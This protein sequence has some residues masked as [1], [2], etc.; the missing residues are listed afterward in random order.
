MS[1]VR[2]LH[3]KAVGGRERF[4]D[5]NVGVGRVQ[6]VTRLVERHVTV[7]GELFR[8]F[9]GDERARRASRADVHRLLLHEAIRGRLSARIR[10]RRGDRGIRLTRHDGREKPGAHLLPEGECISA[11]GGSRTELAP[12]HANGIEQRWDARHRDPER[13]VAIGVGDRDVARTKTDPN[14]SHACDRLRR[15]GELAG[16]ARDRARNGGAVPVEK[17]DDRAGDRRFRRA[18]RDR[19]ADDTLRGGRA[20]N[21]GQNDRAAD[22]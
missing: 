17:N 7:G 19:A 15:D 12:G 21:A 6:H 16:R 10:E 13:P 2:A 5:Q 18:V 8:G 9:G 22:H 1:V 11:I 4:V 14:D 20:R 3:P